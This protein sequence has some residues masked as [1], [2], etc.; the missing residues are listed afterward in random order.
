M[1]GAYKRLDK[2]FKNCGQMPL[3]RGTRYVIF[4]D[5]HRGEGKINDNFLKNQHLYTAAL[6]YYFR[7]GFY[8]IEL[9]DGE[10]LWE[11]HSLERI[12]E[13]YPY[14]YQ[15]QELFQKSHRMSKVYG[16]HDIELK[17]EC[18]ESILLKNTLGEN[19]VWLLHGHQADF[20]N[21]VC[22]PLSKF[23]VRT[24]WKPLEFM[25][26]PDPTSAAKN[27]K[28]TV[29][30]ETIMERYAKEREMYV[31][32]GHS[33][34]PRLCEK[35]CKYANTGSC[36][37]PRS[38]TCIEI[39]GFEMSMIQWVMAARTDLTLQVQ[40]HLMEGPVKIS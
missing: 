22:W 16:N 1:K 3:S 21:S 2:A 6:E 37:H 28:K 11:N 17:D 18:Q 23:L 10:E 27:H 38:V 14:I 4:S 34:R 33:H 35:G 25:G 36:V 12:K 39:E 26:I 5:C 40:R 19:D 32:A 30:Y 24:V 29:K 13:C 20:F 9:G 7:R 31:I 15:L 8:Y